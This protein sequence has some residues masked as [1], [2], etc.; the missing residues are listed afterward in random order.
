MLRKKQNQYK[1]IEQKEIRDLGPKD[2]L[3]NYF[4]EF[5]PNLLSLSLKASIAL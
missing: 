4:V 3:G 2:L 1:N 5:P